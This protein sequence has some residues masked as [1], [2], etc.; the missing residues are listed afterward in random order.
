MKATVK[1][2]QLIPGDVL[3]DGD[4]KPAFTWGGVDG[5]PKKVMRVEHI[6]RV[7]LD[8]WRVCEWPDDHDLD[9]ESGAT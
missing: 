7:V 6:V 2:R 3:L 4:G 5:Q 1:A 9:V 8:D